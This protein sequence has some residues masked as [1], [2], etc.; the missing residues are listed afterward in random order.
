M[1]IHHLQEKINRQS[2]E[3]SETR[4]QLRGY[5]G[6]MTLSLE[7][8]SD[9]DIIRLETLKKD[10]VEHSSLLEVFNVPEFTRILVCDLKPRLARLL[11]PCLPAYL[12][13]AAFRYYDHA[14]DEAGLTGLFSAVH[15]VLKDTITNSSDMDVLSLWLVN[16]WRLLNLLRQYSGES[17][18]EWFAA[19]SQ[20]Q[21]SQ[22]M[23]S[24]DL[25][26]LRD[27]LRARVEESFQNLLKRAI[28]PVLSPKIVPAVL[29]HE[30]SQE[31]VVNG[32]CAENSERRQSTREQN[33]KRLNFIHN[34]L[35]V[36]GADSV[37]LGQVFGQMTYWICALALNH[38]MFR[39]EL[40]NF[41][42]A[43]QIKHNVTEV[44]SWLSANGLSAHRETLEPLVQASHLLQSKKD[45]SNLDTLCGE[46]T[47]R[48]KPKQVIAILQHYTPTDGFE[49][50]RLSSDFLIKISEK[51]NARTRQNGGTEADINMLIMMGTYLTPFNSEPFVYSDFNLQTL[52]LPTCLH[53]QAVCKLL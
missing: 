11:T 7:S 2:D 1:D 40:C 14:R 41:E 28:E 45:E 48:L 23:Q 47:S 31:M 10:H 21:N 18:K 6:R 30:S 8:T 36:Y 51:L 5:S 13:L 42:K 39:K 34:K 26:P 49:E 15:V 38:L 32:S 35:K 22:R 3:L 52:S 50:R 43:I 33:F 12:L 46:M 9:A 29:Q 44:Q 37:L 27:Q 53:L 17:N 20:K 25:G 24:F 19:N 16:S 4:A